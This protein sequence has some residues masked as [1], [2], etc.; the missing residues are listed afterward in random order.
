VT[1]LDAP[2]D[3]SGL[4]HG[5]TGSSLEIRREAEATVVMLTGSLDDAAAPTLRT[6]IDDLH[7][8]RA[9]PTATSGPDPA[10]ARS[11]R[12]SRCRDTWNQVAHRRALC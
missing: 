5:M 1:A 3:A 9:S 8:A 7:R 4:G 12:R 2:R 11:R 10:S 6:A